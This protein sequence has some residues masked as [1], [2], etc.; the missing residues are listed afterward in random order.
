MENKGE[1]R[2]YFGKMRG[3][4]RQN[5]TRWLVTEIDLPLHRTEPT[6]S[7]LVNEENPSTATIGSIEDLQNPNAQS[8]LALDLPPQLPFPPWQ[9]T[10]RVPARSH[11]P[12]IHSDLGWKIIPL[13]ASPLDLFFQKQST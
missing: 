1:A 7:P 3:Q 9:E 10:T 12:H 11:R 8:F 4:S 5:I 2:E 6:Q 13:L